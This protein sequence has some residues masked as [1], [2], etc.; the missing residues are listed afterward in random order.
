MTRRSSDQDVLA[1]R[2]DGS[3]FSAIARQL[4]MKRSSDAYQ[5]FHRALSARPELERPLLAREE[6]ERLVTLEAR[7]RSRDALV[8]DKLH[9]RLEGLEQMR[10]DLRRH[11][12]RPT[13]E[14]QPL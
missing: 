10:E 14:P 6:L 5:A 1:L 13:S 11:L 2:K 9:Q 7:I 4:G 3:S 12:G 8:P